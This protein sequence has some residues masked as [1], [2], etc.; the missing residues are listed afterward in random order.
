MTQAELIWA[1]LALLGAAFE[2]FYLANK[3]SGDTLSEVTRTLFRI[4][5]S[6]VGRIGFGTTWAAFAVWFWGHILYGW[7][8]PLT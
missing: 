3:R 1:G 8:F 4:R 2:T 5:S 7:P 6:R